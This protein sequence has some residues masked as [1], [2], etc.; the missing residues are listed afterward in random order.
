MILVHIYR[1]RRRCN[2]C[3]TWPGGS[4]FLVC[5]GPWTGPMVYFLI[6]RLVI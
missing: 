2:R 5:C 6:Q 3:W 4:F 1:T